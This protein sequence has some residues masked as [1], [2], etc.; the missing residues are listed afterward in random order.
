MASFALLLSA[1]A[2][3]PATVRA[4]AIKPFFVT[5]ATNCSTTMW[6][7]HFYFQETLVLIAVLNHSKRNYFQN[8]K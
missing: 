2:G 3:I 5:F 4:S 8:I 7:N 6:G 1:E